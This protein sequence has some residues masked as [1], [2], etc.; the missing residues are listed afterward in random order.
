MRY[1]KNSIIL[2]CLLVRCIV[3]CVYLVFS[4][5]TDLLAAAFKFERPFILLVEN[6]KKSFNYAKDIFY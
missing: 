6:V 5:I 3:Y 1:L 2:I 4:L